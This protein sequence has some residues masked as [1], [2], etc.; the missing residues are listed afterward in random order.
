M[1]P[2]QKKKL[3]LYASELFTVFG[4]IKNKKDAEKFLN[5]FLTER[6][7]HDVSLRWQ[8]VKRLAKDMPHRDISDELGISI[9]KV[10]RGSKALAH[11]NGAFSKLLGK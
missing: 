4:K 5:D 2:A 10:T 3:S 7:L 11:N 8:L 9:A 6:E 1:K